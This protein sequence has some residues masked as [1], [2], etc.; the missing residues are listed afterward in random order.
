[1]KIKLVTD[2]SC[3]IPKEIYEKE[4][5]G[6]FESIIMYEEKEYRELTELDRKEFLNKLHK[7]SPYPTTTQVSSQD[8][9]DVLTK[10]VEDGYDDV[11][12]LGLS[13]NLSSQMNV[14]RLASKRVKNLKLTM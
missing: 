13:P 8:V 12:Y 2:A 10:A 7:L 6:I 5:I 1:M 11:L 4:D 3:L 9:V 14:V